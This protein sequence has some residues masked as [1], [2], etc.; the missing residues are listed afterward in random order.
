M[1]NYR[2]A[3]PLAALA[4]LAACGKTAAPTAAVTAGAAPATAGGATVELVQ[5][6]RQDPPGQQTYAMARDLGYTMCKAS[7]EILKKPVKPFP[8]MPAH[9]GEV[10]IT[11]I[12]NGT[13]MV[14]KQETAYKDSDELM[15][16]ETGCEYQIKPIKTVEIQITHAGKVIDMAGEGGPPKIIDTSEGVD[17]GDQYKGHKDTKK[18]TDPRTVNGVTLRCVPKDFW[19][20]NTNKVLDMRDM[21]VYA[22]DGVVIDLMHEPIIVQSVVLANIINEKYKF[23]QILEPVSLR[24]IGSSE[25]DPFQASH[26]SA[27]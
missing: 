9:Y 14:T 6:E 21:C 25:P 23:M 3:L 16:P 13:S 8:P 18:Y 26:Y 15:H 10:R 27:Q 17:I 20:L 19:L 4:L 1:T 5:L 22:K 12:T 24:T 7:A 11:T 2:N